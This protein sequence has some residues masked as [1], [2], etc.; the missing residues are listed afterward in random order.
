MTGFTSELGGGRTIL[1]EES[2]I[3]RGRDA[4]TSLLVEGSQSRS[5]SITYTR[6]T[7]DCVDQLE[8]EPV[9]NPGVITVGEAPG[10]AGRDDIRTEAV[11][12]PSDLTGPGIAIGEILAEWD[13]PVVARFASLTSVLQYVDFDTA[14][15]FLHAITGRIH[16]AGA[17]AHS[18]IDPGA[19]D[20]TTLAGLT[21]LLDARVAVGD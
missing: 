20:G 4:C 3:G 5:L 11:T 1:L 21:S 18:H 2:P 13:D 8:D 17:R 7:A 6:G 19:H 12:T 14:H 10:T 15:E 9:D 16:S